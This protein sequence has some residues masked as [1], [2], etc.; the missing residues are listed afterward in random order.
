M[1]RKFNQDEE[2]TH[3]I[4]ENCSTIVS[5]QLSQNKGSSKLTL[6]NFVNFNWD[7]CYYRGQLIALH[8]SEKFIAYG[9][10]KRKK[11]KYL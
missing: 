9:F 8:I 7:L 1:Y 4:N 2:T 10:T 5:S 3:L 11:T 6:K